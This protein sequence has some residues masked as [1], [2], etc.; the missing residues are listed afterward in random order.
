[1]NN[2]FKRIV[3]ITLA[4]VLL[5]STASAS[6]W[7]IFY[8]PNAPSDVSNQIDTVRMKYTNSYYVVKCTSS[9][10][11]T[12]EYTPGIRIRNSDGDGQFSFAHAGTYH[13]YPDCKQVVSYVD[14]T[15]TAIGG[16]KISASGTI[17]LK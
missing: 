13:Y 9:S 6:S 7:S 14:V 8:V 2:N 5:I 12:G 17:V 4:V 3:T 15:F 1:M 11:P 10:V 16:K